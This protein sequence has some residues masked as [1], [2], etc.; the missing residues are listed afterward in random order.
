MLSVR[1]SMSL[2][3]SAVVCAS[4]EPDYDRQGRQTD[5]RS[6]LPSRGGG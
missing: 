4:V 2:V 6:S 5:V 1:Q 3:V